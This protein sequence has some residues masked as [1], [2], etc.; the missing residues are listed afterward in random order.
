MANSILSSIDPVRLT[1]FVREAYANRENG[2]LLLST[3]LPTQAIDDIEAEFASGGIGLRDA[4]VYRSFDA[5]SPIAAKPGLAM[6]KVKLPPISVKSMLSE[7]ERLKLQRASDERVRDAVNI[8]AG[9]LAED[10]ADRVEL[11]RSEALRT[12]QIVLAENGVFFT[13]DFGRAGSHAASAGTAWSTTA[14][15]SPVT[16]LLACRTLIRAAGGNPDRILMND[17]TYAKMIATDEVKAAASPTGTAGIP[18][19][20]AGV[21]TVLSAYGLPPVTVYVAVAQIAGSAAPIIPD[22]EV[23]M[24]ATSQLGGVFT[25]RTADQLGDATLVNL[26]GGIVGRTWETPDPAAAWTKAAAIALPVLANPNLSV[27]LTVS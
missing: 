27:G 5:E 1:G 2:T 11:A 15:A 22:D 24:V 12:G 13:I 6:N 7:Y 16:D 17:T 8:D 19:S 10:V 23:I 18:P 20:E 21:S 3:I 14:S 25:G 26:P 9:S 4:A